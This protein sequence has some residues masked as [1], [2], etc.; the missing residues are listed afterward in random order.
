MKKKTI[1]KENKQIVEIH[2]YIHQV[3]PNGVGQIT[4]PTPQAP[5]INP[6]TNPPYYVTF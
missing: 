5:Y 1:K 3:N 2:N 6:V 4:Y